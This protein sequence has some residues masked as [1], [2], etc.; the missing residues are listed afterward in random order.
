[1][2]EESSIGGEIKETDCRLGQR[3]K[4]VGREGKEVQDGRKR[5]FRGKDLS[6]FPEDP[7]TM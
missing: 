3:E 7:M 2:Q 1:M 6:S 4:E 5:N